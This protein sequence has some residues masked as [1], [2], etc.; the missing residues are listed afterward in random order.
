LFFSRK[1]KLPEISIDFVAFHTK[2]LIVSEQDS[3]E[4]KAHEQ[5]STSQADQDMFFFLL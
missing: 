3:K 2:M 1:P 4:K 5:N